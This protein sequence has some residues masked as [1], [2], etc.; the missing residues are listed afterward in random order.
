MLSFKTFHLLGAMDSV[1]ATDWTAS[2]STIALTS[3]LMDLTLEYGPFVQ[4][5]D[6][7][8][9]ASHKVYAV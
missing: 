9:V 4:L 7:D 1:R 3:R 8:P 6:E 2:M 5:R